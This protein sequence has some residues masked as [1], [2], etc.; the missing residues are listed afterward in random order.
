ML[1][2]R[3]DCLPHLQVRP[4]F[5]RNAHDSP[6]SARHSRIVVVHDRG[7]L[8][9]DTPVLRHFLAVIPCLAWICSCLLAVSASGRSKACVQRAVIWKEERKTTKHNFNHLPS[10]N[11]YHH[12]LPS[13]SSGTAV[14]SSALGDRERRSGCCI[15][16]AVRQKTDNN[17]NTK[18]GQLHNG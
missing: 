3:D 9:I 4:I 12:Y 8:T 6:T 2:A 18:T 5:L 17:W 14:E 10:L 13:Q 1:P 15:Y 11:S 16:S 7:I